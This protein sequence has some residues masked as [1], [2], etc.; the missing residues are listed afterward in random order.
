MNIN[1]PEL[2]GKKYKS[3]RYYKYMGT[4]RIAVK[5]MPPFY[6]VTSSGDF[7]HSHAYKMKKTLDRVGVENKLHD[8][9]GK[10]SRTYFP[11]W[12]RPRPM[13]ENA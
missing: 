4:D 13:Q 3:S 8:F 1:L 6:I 12:I 2:L 10:Y 9:K 5:N 11:Y 7:L